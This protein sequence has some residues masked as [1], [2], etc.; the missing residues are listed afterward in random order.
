[1]LKLDRRDISTDEVTSLFSRFGYEAPYSVF[2]E[3]W[4]RAF[5]KANKISDALE[6]ANRI[7]DKMMGVEDD[8][9]F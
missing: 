5:Y 3:L 9:P 2:A 8:V 6:D 1:M 4:R 7:L